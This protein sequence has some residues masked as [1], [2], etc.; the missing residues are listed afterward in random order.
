MYSI[1]KMYVSNQ[2]RQR[3]YNKLRKNE[4]LN[5][6]NQQEILDGLIAEN[7][8]LDDQASKLTALSKRL[9]LK[10][11][12]EETPN[13]LKKK[14]KDVNTN[15]YN[16]NRMMSN[17]DINMNNQEKKILEKLLK[18]IEKNKI[19]EAFERLEENKN[20]MNNAYADKIKKNLR[21]LLLNKK[22]NERINK[23]RINKIDTNERK[24]PTS[25]TNTSIMSDA[26]QSI[27]LRT[28]QGGN[29]PGGRPKKPIMKSIQDYETLAINK[30][31]TNS[32]LTVNQ[33]KRLKALYKQVRENMGE[34]DIRY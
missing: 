14:F 17:E 18:L 26:P 30:Y 25:P 12:M 28:K 19:E 33:K 34:E 2:V 27:D 6:I 23:K 8:G 11:E 13:I 29:N 20:L 24:T 3:R 32:K 15:S 16:E 7:L 5:Y 22:I 10:A 21:T 9:K 4:E 1:I 31:K